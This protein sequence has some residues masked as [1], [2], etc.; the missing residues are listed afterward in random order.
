MIVFKSGGFEHTNPSKT[1]NAS[2][3]SMRT[4]TRPPVPNTAAPVNASPNDQ[5]G[6]LGY[7][8][9]NLSKIPSTIYEQ[10]RT[11]LGLGGVI[12]QFKLPEN[13]NPNRNNM[14]DIFNVFASPEQANEEAYNIL[15]KLGAKPETAK[16]MTEHR[17]EDWKA[18][19]LIQEL[20]WLGTGIIK[21]MGARSISPLIHYGLQTAA[22]LGG[23][24]TVGQAASQLGA[25]LGLSEQMSSLGGLIGTAAGSIG[26]GQVAREYNM[27]PEVRQQ[28]YKE[29]QQQRKAENRNDYI[30]QQANIHAASDK[31]IM[32]AATAREEA[33]KKAA[34]ERENE[35]GINNKTLVRKLE[36]SEA[37]K[38]Q[39][40]TETERD[41]PEKV[42]DLLVKERTKK[43]A[44]PLERD[45]FNKNKKEK[46]EN[47]DAKGRAYDQEMQTL[48]KKMIENKEHENLTG[49]AHGDGEQ[50]LSVIDQAGSSESRLQSGMQPHDITAVAN[51]MNPIADAARNENGISLQQAKFFY[52]NG[53]DLLFDHGTTKISDSAKKVVRQV[54]HGKDGLKDFILK[55]GPEEHTKSWI[56]YND[57]ASRY[58]KLKEG[59]PEFRADLQEERAAIRKEKMEEHA[60]FTAQEEA[61]KAAAERKKVQDEYETTKRKAISKAET[62]TERAK[63]EHKNKTEDIEE[64]YKKSKTN[65]EEA[66][67]KA[68]QKA[69]AKRQEDLKIAEKAHNE[70]QEAIG[71]ET[72]DDFIND[73]EKDDATQHKI[74]N[75]INHGMSKFA[76]STLG[77]MFGFSKFGATGGVLLGAT[78]A[79]AAKVSHELKLTRK[80]LA[81]HPHIYKEMMATVNKAKKQDAAHALIQFNKLGNKIEKYAQDYKD[82]PTEKTETIFKTGGFIR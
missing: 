17:P 79:L 44:I 12:N 46:I 66:E 49:N 29:R 20:P 61:K 33:H 55:N 1:A 60:Q 11:G 6:L 72:F 13:I 34:I 21:S 52:E 77:L 69:E 10:A 5:E 73:I 35:L 71:K 47:V 7:I 62:E 76:A 54:M 51:Y 48:H 45:A 75:L 4:V 22:S 42:Q 82:E 25:P 67:N 53:N 58:A 28:A 65:A 26:A 41:L 70:A 38:N 81:D 31:D 2:S 23:G 27:G 63:R 39:V 15:T 36:E 43:E 80:V 19:M 37:V 8:G 9:R 3:Q 57:S 78:G 74:I 24:A 56:D 40:L 14:A 18:E 32:S 68:K 30:T 64:Q 59:R 16:Y 50:L